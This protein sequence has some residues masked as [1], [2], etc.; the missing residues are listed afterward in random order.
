MRL[1]S[2]EMRAFGPYAAAQRIDFDLL[3]SSGLF[4]LEG[5][6]GAGKSTILDA[7]TFA[8]YGGLA[9]RGP[10]RTGCAPISPAGRRAIGRAGVLA[11]RRP[12][13]DDASTRASAAQ[14][15]RRRVH[16]R[17]EPG[18][19]GAD[20]S[21]WLVQPV[22]EQGRG[23]RGD[24]RGGRA[25]PR[26][27]HPGHAPATGRV[28]TVPAG[29]RRRPAGTAHQAVRHPVRT[30][31]S[32][33]N[34]TAAARRRSGSGIALSGR[35]RTRYRRRARRLAWMPANVPDW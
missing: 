4:L 19:P 23:R 34:S 2:L 21:R 30:T 3:A 6:T 35:S 29:P 15:A 18:P 8:L 13:P 7:V 16:D 24:H 27:V 20:G 17:G 28:R 22:L 25:Q 31:A 1:H 26:P 10:A 11:P 12:V 5:P 14:E 32:P 9:G 33:P